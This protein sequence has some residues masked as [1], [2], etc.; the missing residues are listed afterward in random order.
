MAHVVQVKRSVVQVIAQRVV[1]VV[2]NAVEESVLGNVQG[3]KGVMQHHR[4]VSQVVRANRY[5]VMETVR[6]HRHLMQ[7]SARSYQMTDA[8]LYQRV[9]VDRNAVMGHVWRVVRGLSV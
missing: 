2:R 9:R 4:H 7:V 3:V 5:V 8:V 1:R 6:H